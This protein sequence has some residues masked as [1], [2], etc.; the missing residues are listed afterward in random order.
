[1]KNKKGN[2]LIITGLLLLAAALCLMGYNLYEDSRAEQ[3][4][5]QVLVSLNVTLPVEK[6]HPAEE[7]GDPLPTEEHQSA[8]VEMPEQ[9]LIPDYLLNPDMPMPEQ[10]INGQDYIG[11]LEI[12]AC[13]LTL[14]VISQWS[15]PSLKVA[16]CR[17]HGSAYTDD[18][19]IV[20]HNYKAHFRRLKELQ[21]GDEVRFTDVDG[22]VFV[23]EV[24]VLETLEPTA[25]EE[26]TSGQWDLTLFTCTTGGSYRLTV[27]CQ[28][29]E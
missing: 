5:E 20:A 24:T 13:D 14:P 27:R 19:V 22:N 12:P 16:P 15:Y 25:V 21:P 9:G 10:S 7:T 26:M 1:M 8:E 28:K 29:I 18:L 3:S 17:Y 6:D 11:V 23:Y 4:V 2:F